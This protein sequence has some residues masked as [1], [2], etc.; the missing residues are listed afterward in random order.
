MPAHEEPLNPGDQ[1]L[2]GTPGSGE[3]LC[4]DCHGSG[5]CND[6]PCTTCGGTGKVIEGIGGG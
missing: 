6:A 4:P 2:A 5:M 1:A 3:N